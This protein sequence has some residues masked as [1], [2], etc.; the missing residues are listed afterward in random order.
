M[1]SAHDG[2]TIHIERYSGGK[3]GSEVVLYEVRGG[4]HTEPSRS[5]RYGFLYRLVVGRQNGD[6][7]M[8][9]EVWKFFSAHALE[10]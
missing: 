10:N 3:A 5:E 9:D 6:M 2:G 4:G 7:E 1:K 8:A